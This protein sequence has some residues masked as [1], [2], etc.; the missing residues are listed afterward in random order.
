[1]HLK[2]LSFFCP[3]FAVRKKIK[4]VFY[5][6]EEKAIV[7]LRL[8]QQINYILSIDNVH[9]NY[10]T[11]AEIGNKFCGLYSHIIFCYYYHCYFTIKERVSRISSF[12]Q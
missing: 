12:I 11:L 1:M 4:F 7:L 8:Q 6:D 5:N 2:K 10:T 9:F 3:V